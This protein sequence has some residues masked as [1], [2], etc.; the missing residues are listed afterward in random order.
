MAG[1]RDEAAKLAKRL[2]A[3]L[4]LPEC[5]A[6][7]LLRASLCGPKVKVVHYSCNIDGQGQGFFVALF[8][9]KGHI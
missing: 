9:L 2:G 3:S 4:H 6:V 1:E 7:S 8:F 5:S